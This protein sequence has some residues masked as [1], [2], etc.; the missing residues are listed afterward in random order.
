MK[1]IELWQFPLKGFG[2]SQ[3]KFARLRPGSYFPNDRQFAIS[4]G[5]AKTTHAIFSTWFPKAHFLQL[6]SNETLAEYSC[7]YSEN[8]SQPE[9]ELFHFGK[10]C[11]RINPKIP[12]DCQNLEI[13]IAKNLEKHLKGQPRLMQNKAQAFSDQPTPLISIVYKSSLAAFA[14]A[15]NTIADNRRFRINIVIDGG[16]AFTEESLIGKKIKLGSAL[17]YVKKPVGRCAA[18]NV[19]PKTAF[20]SDCDYVA[21]MKREFGHSNIGIFAEVLNGGSINVGDPLG[22]Q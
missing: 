1:I 10:I 20:R 21:V 14:S 11:I 4:I 2:G 12:D 5:T 8:T 6:M 22:Q 19:D 9:L 16:D 3:I 17:L 13:F 7:R 15:T 18:I